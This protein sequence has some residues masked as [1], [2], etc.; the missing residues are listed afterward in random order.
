[1]DLLLIE[2]DP[3]CLRR[4]VSAIDTI[5]TLGSVGGVHE[6]HVRLRRVQTLVREGS[7]LVRLRNALWGGAGKQGVA[8]LARAHLSGGC[9]N[10]LYLEIFPPP[11]SGRRSPGASS[12]CFEVLKVLE[13]LAYRA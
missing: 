2:G 7:P 9:R 11:P 6:P 8:F 12:R 3:A 5:S 10:K 1:M 4:T 13:T